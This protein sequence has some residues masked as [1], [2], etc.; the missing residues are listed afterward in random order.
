VDGTST[1]ASR[2]KTLP[3]NPCVGCG[4]WPS[5]LPIRCCRLK[6][7]AAGYSAGHN[8]WWMVHVVLKVVT[9]TEFSDIGTLDC[10]G[11]QP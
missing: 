6:D 8:T 5:I 7:V 3:C 1:W 11:M 2:Q 4:V 9:C 10:L